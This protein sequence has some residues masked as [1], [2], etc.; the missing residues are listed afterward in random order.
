MLLTSYGH[1]CLL[2]EAGDT[3]VLID[4][5]IFST[6]FESL[7]G[8]DAIMITHQHPDHADPGRLTQVV[9]ANPGA[10]LHAEREIAGQLH[11]AHGLDFTVLV[12]GR[13]VTIGGLTVEPVGEWHAVIHASLPRV[14][15]T[16]LLIH[17]PGEP[18]LYHPGDAIDTAPGD[19]DVLCVPVSAPWSAM[20]ETVD[21]VAK[22][23]P[24]T[25]LPIHDAIL[26]D[27]GRELYMRQIANLSRQ[28][29]AA[30]PRGWVEVRGTG[31]AD[32]GA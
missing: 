13:Q 10:G 7:R 4:P 18:R 23:N 12:P 20:K 30:E 26:S 14:H 15:N 1:S 32:V 29:G 17:A 16:G 21:W 28:P 24:G 22:V 9:R 31:A 2:V 8:L 19:V 5:G 3:R 27:E 25:I 11:D 6:G